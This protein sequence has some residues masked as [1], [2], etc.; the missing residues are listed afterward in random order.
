MV[1]LAV[2]LRDK[3]TSSVSLRRD[4]ST[5]SF[6]LGCVI[7]TKLG[8]LVPPPAGAALPGY[9]VPPVGTNAFLSVSAPVE[10]DQARIRARALSGAGG[11][12]AAA[13]A[14]SLC[15]LTFSFFVLCFSIL[16]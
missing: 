2:T 9:R 7:A 10:P 4:E 13:A 12:A 11:A 1:A 16:S 3:L 6:K 14:A 15:S 5:Q 8:A